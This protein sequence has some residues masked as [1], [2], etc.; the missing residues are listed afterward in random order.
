MFGYMGIE[1][2]G[3][4]LDCFRKVSWDYLIKIM[5]SYFSFRTSE[6]KKDAC[7]QKGAM[8]KEQLLQQILNGKE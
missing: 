6:I 2:I 1:S 5:L 4:F 8:S 3:F 7:F